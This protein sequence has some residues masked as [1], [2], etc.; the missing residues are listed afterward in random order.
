VG[1]SLLPVL[2]GEPL[3]ASRVRL[4][5]GTI[6]GP[7]RAATVIEGR[8]EAWD[9]GF[10]TEVPTLE[11]YDLVADPS[12][13]S[14]VTIAGEPPSLSGSAWTVFR[15]LAVTGQ[16]ALRVELLPSDDG[17]FELEVDFPGRVQLAGAAPSE[18]AEIQLSR[19]GSRHTVSALVLEPTTLW[20]Q[21]DG[22][23]EQ[24]DRVTLRAIGGD[25]VD[26]PRGAVVQGDAVGVP[27]PWSLY[28]PA[29]LGEPVPEGVRARVRWSFPQGAARGGV[30]PDTTAR[31]RALGYID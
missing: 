6:Y 25:A 22:V 7:A 20:L 30:H 4:A 1:R 23:Q 16:L 21:L 12:E 26:W 28:R 13:R 15:D 19:A 24:F 17:P 31:L 18:G 14:P 8:K 11:V 3:P 9:L 10:E 27:F 5:A 2:A 29:D